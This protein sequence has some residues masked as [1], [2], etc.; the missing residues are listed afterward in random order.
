MKVVLQEVV[1]ILLYN[2]PHPDN[3]GSQSGPCASLGKP[4]AGLGR[5]IT[6]DL[7]LQLELFVLTECCA[8]VVHGNSVMNA[9]AHSSLYV[10]DF[11]SLHR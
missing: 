8:T 1:N 3:P 2:G 10:I 6:V 4:Y 7:R 5:L 11:T 9:I